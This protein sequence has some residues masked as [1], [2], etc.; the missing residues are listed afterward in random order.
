MLGTLANAAAIIIGS[1]VGTLVRSRL[2]QRYVNVAFQAAGLFTL[3]IGI[4]MALKS[5]NMILIVISLISGALIG[6]ALN[7]DGNSEKAANSLL[8]KFANKDSTSTSLSDQSEPAGTSKLAVEGFVT[9]SV[10]FCTGSMAI[11]GAF[12]DGMGKPPQLLYTKS[13]I[14]GIASVAFASTFGIFV[15]LSA[16][17]V[18]IY[19]GCLTLFAAYIMQFLTESMIADLTAVGGVLLIGLGINILKIKDIK[20]IN[21]LPALVVV[22]LLSAF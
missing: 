5:N 19:Q 3:V 2:P 4:S 15:G 9:A 17:P 13:I 7:L 16:I 1:T 12:E 14:D 6:E 20:V 11:L 21:M 22:V 18:L 8:K 10:L